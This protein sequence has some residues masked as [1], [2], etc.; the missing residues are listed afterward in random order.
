[1]WWDKKM[2]AQYEVAASEV[3]SNT[4]RKKVC[5]H[6]KNQSKVHQQYITNFIPQKKL[7]NKKITID[8]KHTK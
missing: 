1:M 5:I 3:N 2:N 7:R 8:L 6:T 4:L